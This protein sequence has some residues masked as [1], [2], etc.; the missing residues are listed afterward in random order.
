MLLFYSTKNTIAF[1]FSPGGTPGPIGAKN[2]NRISFVITYNPALPNIQRILH[3]KQP[4][5][6]A[7]ER[8][9]KFLRILLLSRTVVHQGSCVHL[10]FVISWSVQ[11]LKNPN[12]FF[13]AP[14]GSFRYNSKHGCLNA[15]VYLQYVCNK[16][17]LKR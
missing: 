14:P 17:K 11:K 9:M 16:N 1:Y 15:A 12:K 3:K 8:L 6:H 5:L 4:I 10:I 7:S 13:K 2:T